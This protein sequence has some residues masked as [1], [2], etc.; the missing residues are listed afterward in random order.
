[1]AKELKI[2]PVGGNILVKPAKEEETTASGL[3][4]QTSG[5]GEKPQK[6]EI[7]AVGSGLL[8]DSGKLIPFNVKVGQTVMFKKYSPEDVEIDGEDY[9]IM[10]ESDILAIFND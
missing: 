4:I 3:I 8:D 6:G 10:K 9:L 7:V 5:K 1:M 2:Q